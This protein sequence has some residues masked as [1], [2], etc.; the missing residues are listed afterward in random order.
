M[1]A[2]PA[3]ILAIVC[4]AAADRD[5]AT[6]LADRVL[7]REVDWLEPESLP[8]YRRWQGLEEGS[9]HLEWH[10]IK[11]LAE[12]HR[13]KPH[14]HFRGE[15]GDLNAHEAHKALLLLVE[16]SPD[17]VVLVRDTDGEERRRRGLEQARDDR[18]WPFPVVLGLAHSKRECWVLAGFHP[19]TS[20]EEK[21]LAR[22][23][24]ELGFDPCTGAEGLYASSP[25]AQRDAKR[26]LAALV[27]GPDRERACW[28]DADLE[29]LEERGQSTGLAEYLGEVRSRLVP[30]FLRGD[31]E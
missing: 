12:G 14:G 25:G 2:T 15:P 5:T 11:S 28:A 3:Y 27:Q 18:P 19:Q 24:K 16:A 8:L 13:F 7:C 30:L 29:V 17:A 1:S 21:T 6:E 26:V 4:E 22:L 20:S 23:R 10:W 9:R 31:A